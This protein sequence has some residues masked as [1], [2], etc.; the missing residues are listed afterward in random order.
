LRSK[1]GQRRAEDAQLAYAFVLRQDFG[2][3]AAGPAAARKFGIQRRKAS[4]N[5]RAGGARKFTAAPDAGMAF[6][7]GGETHPVLSLRLK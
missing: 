6:E 7:F 3:R 5:A 2:E 1:L 4:G